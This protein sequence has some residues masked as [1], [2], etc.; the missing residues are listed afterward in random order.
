MKFLFSFTIKH[1]VSTLL[2]IFPFLTNSQ[3]IKVLSA[4]LLFL[5]ASF[6]VHS[7]TIAFGSCHK[8]KDSNSDTIL[9]SIANS[10]PDAFV[11]LGDVVYG[12]DGKPKHLRKRFR[13]LKA[14]ESY[15]ALLQATKVFGTWDDHDYGLNNA[16]RNYKHKAQSRKD[17]LHFLSIPKDNPVYQHLGVYQSYDLGKNKQTKLI[18]L[19]NRY[20]KTPYKPKPYNDPYPPDY[21]GTILG[22]EQWVW[23]ENELKNSSA[24]VHLF[25]S[26]VQFLS[27][28]HPFEKWQNYPNEAKRFV[29]LLKKYNLKNPIFL[30]GDRHMSELSQ[31][32]IGYTM[33]YDATSSGMTEALTNNLNEENPYRVG[34]SIGVN[35]YGVL[36]IDW[37]KRNI[38]FSFLDIHGKSLFDYN[39][40]LEN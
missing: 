16:G 19:D 2:F 21:D 34:N 6:L 23:L 11:W 29:A 14:K 24:K 9:T 20:L 33:L 26:G 40:P 7:Q 15:Q 28:N 8:V 3:M 35:S 27:P 12:K 1:G 4:S 5:C 32:D 18:L 22:E 36:N 17:F 39:V 30:T 13:Q 37:E 10:L 31:K 25:A 38:N